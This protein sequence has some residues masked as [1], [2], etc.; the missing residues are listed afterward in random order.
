MY[1]TGRL[2]SVPSCSVLY[3]P[4]L[5]SHLWLALF[6]RNAERAFFFVRY[7][8]DTVNFTLSA[9][10]GVFCCSGLTTS[11][12]VCGPIVEEPGAKALTA[13]ALW[14]MYRI[15]EQ[16]CPVAAVQLAVKFTLPFAPPVWGP[17]MFDGV[18]Y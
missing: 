16:V 11:A 1:W 9:K 5:R 15:P 14:K 4:H 3:W 12:L 18:P 8:R 6:Q 17:T 13:G 7:F 10:V 2:C